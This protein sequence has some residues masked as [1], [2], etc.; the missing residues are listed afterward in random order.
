MN[1]GKIRESN[2]KSLMKTNILPFFYLYANKCF[3]IEYS[4]FICFS[5]PPK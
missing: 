5:T 3:L 4:S 2:E 1:I